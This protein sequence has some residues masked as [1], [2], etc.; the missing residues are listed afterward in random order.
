M[1]M[2]DGVNWGK[3]TRFVAGESSDVEAASMRAWA[4]EDPQHAALLSSLR[5]AWDAADAAEPEWDEVAAWKN[6]RA[7]VHAAPSGLDHPE[8]AAP[9][10]LAARSGFRRWWPAKRMRVAAAVIG[11][12]GTGYVGARALLTGSAPP[13]AM[14]ELITLKGERAEFRLA[15]GTRVV[16]GPES[17]LRVPVNFGAATREVH[18]AGQAFFDVTEDRERPFSVHAGGV[19][20]RVLGTEFNVRAYPEE[21]EV[22][23]VVAEGRVLVHAEKAAEGTL[24]TPGDLG[25]LRVGATQVSTR[26]VDIE[27]H[28]G[29]RQGRLTFDRTPLAQVCVDLERWYGIPVRVADPSLANLRV[30]ASFR[31]HSLDEVVALVAASL[32][33][34][35]SLSGRTV[36]FHPKSDPVR[37][38]R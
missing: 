38:A 16:V 12:L 5:L 34:R 9:S 11:L 26:K 25:E 10:P 13:E 19:V 1:S 17:R 22:A 33:L 6:V 27:D 36:L 8:S 15:D 32:D 37:L 2:D 23:V 24:L 7:R 18:L 14:Q 31:D 30:T 4:A 28:V 35:H 29:W 21:T 3:I 20:T